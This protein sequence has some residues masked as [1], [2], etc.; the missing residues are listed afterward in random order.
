MTLTVGSLFSGVEGIGR[1]LEATKGFEIIWQSEIDPYACAV[2]RSHWPAVPNLGDI[3]KIDWEKV[4]RPDVLCGGF[5]CQD[6]SVAG[7]GAGIKEGTRSGLWS[8][9]AKAIRILRPKYA[10]IENVPMLAKRGLH[11]VLA[12]LAQ[13]GYDAEWHNLS[14]SS[15]GA[16]HKRERLFIVAYSNCGGCDIRKSF[17]QEPK[18][19]FFQEWNSKK[20]RESKWKGWKRWLGAFYKNSDRQRAELRASGMDDGDAFRVHRIKC[21]GNAV[22]PQCAESI[23]KYILEIETGKKE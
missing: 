4:R 15:V 12:D 9:Y 3:T 13:A 7:R 10:L 16:P 2:L 18:D 22:V 19:I 20:A 5:P 14:A 6:I 11:I 17:T 23:G 1:G 21:L 8:E